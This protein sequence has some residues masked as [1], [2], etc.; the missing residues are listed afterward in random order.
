MY[1]IDD[2]IINHYQLYHPNENSDYFKKAIT[3]VANVCFVERR[4]GTKLRNKSMGMLMTVPHLEVL[5]LHF[6]EGFFIS[7]HSQ[8]WKY[9]FVRIE[10]PY[11]S[12]MRIPL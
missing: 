9:S 11:I 2:V 12:R 7:R 3:T 10:S 5:T 4:S 8:Q 1:C 6:A